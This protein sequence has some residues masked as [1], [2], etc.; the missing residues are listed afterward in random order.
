MFCSRGSS[1]WDMIACRPT[2]RPV[3]AASMVMEVSHLAHPV[4]CMFCYFVLVNFSENIM[5]MNQ[6][7]IGLTCKVCVTVHSV[8]GDLR[9]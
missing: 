6:W 4:V 3:L 1:A 5:A 7:L 9:F 2:H 8:V